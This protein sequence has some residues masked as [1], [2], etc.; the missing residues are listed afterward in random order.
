LKAW[1]IGELFVDYGS[2][3][4]VEVYESSS[5]AV[6]I[7]IVY[8]AASNPTSKP[9]TL[10]EIDCNGNNLFVGQDTSTCPIE[11]I[12]SWAEKNTHKTVE[13]WCKVCENISSDACLMSA[14]GPWALLEEETKATEPEVIL[15]TFFGGFGA[16]L[17]FMF[18]CI[19]FANAFR[20]NDQREPIV[21][22]NVVHDGQP[23]QDES[24]IM[25][26]D[27]ADHVNDDEKSLASLS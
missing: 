9:V 21:P 4:V 19:T 3:I 6:S 1:D 2:A 18:L 22:H 7:R 10:S 20:G 14:A 13:N 16:G 27:E 8:K 25:Q 17:V 11:N 15:G 5:Q 23:P 24:N 26:L 12:I